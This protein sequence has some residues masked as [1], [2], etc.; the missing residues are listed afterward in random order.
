MAT[1]AHRCHS[2]FLTLERKLAAIEA[3]RDA[4]T[5]V[6]RR[7]Y[8]MALQRE[9]VLGE[10]PPATPKGY[11]EMRFFHDQ[12]QRLEG[13]IDAIVAAASPPGSVTVSPATVRRL[14][15]T[16]DIKQ[17]S[18]RTSKRLEDAYN[19]EMDERAEHVVQNCIGA[20]VQEGLVQMKGYVNAEGQLQPLSQLK[21]PRP[22]N[23]ARQFAVDEP[24]PEPSESASPGTPDA[25]LY[26]EG[27]AGGVSSEEADE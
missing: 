9:H 15:E 12:L 23:L 8:E 25:Q 7:E 20:P 19:K 1:R 22:T 10:S 24:E 27:C 26:A 14:H 18:P 11:K 3:E 6:A 17:L 4:A 16:Y 13:K 5:A 2:A 21:T